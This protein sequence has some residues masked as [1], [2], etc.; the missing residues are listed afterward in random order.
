MSTS[1]LE[2]LSKLKPNILFLKYDSILKDKENYYVN[3]F[4]P[5]FF[6]LLYLSCNIFSFLKYFIPKNIN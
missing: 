6:F 5:T 4:L 1:T 2:S 3:D